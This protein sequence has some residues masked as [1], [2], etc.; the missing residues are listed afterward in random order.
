MNGRYQRKLVASS[1]YEAGVY[2]GTDEDITTNGIKKTGSVDENGN[3]TGMMGSSK[4][5]DYPSS[6]IAET[7]QDIVFNLNI[8]ADSPMKSRMPTLAQINELISK[9]TQ[10]WTTVDGVEGMRFTASNGNSIFL[11]AAGYRDGE[12][13]T[14]DNMGYYWSG[15]ANTLFFYN[16]SAKTGFSKRNLGLSI[17]SVRPYANINPDGGK[18]L[19]GDLEK[20]GNFR[21]EIYN[22]FGDSRRR[23]QN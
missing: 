6:D 17:R 14:T 21:I 2:Y 5:E 22:D 8:D 3:V 13:V 16:T 15:N 23:C 4:I 19:F 12:T 9:T 11:P 7:M 18:V 10:K 1:F 20:N